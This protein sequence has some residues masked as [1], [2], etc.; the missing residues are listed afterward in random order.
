MRCE[1]A[2]AAAEEAKG[3]TRLEAMRAV[4]ANVIIQLVV[5]AASAGSA[6]TTP[7]FPENRELVE[8]IGQSVDS[9]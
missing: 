9:P 3:L 2:R 6:F 4:R 8:Y 5:G 1:D 7:A